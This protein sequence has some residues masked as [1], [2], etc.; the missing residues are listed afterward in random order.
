[1]N[2]LVIGYGSIGERHARI[3]KQMGYHVS[4]VSQRLDIDKYTVFHSI[5]TAMSCK[6]FNYVIIANNTCDHFSAMMELGRLTYK[7]LL[8]IEKPVFD[9][10]KVTPKF[11]SGSVFVAYN[12]RFHPV[13]L[14]IYRLLQ[15]KKIY[16]MHVYCGQYLPTWR[17]GNNYQKS[18]SAHKKS[19]GGVLRDLSHELDYINWMTGGWKSVSSIGG[20]FSDLEIDSDDVFCLLLETERCPAISLQVNYLDRQPRREMIINAEKLS[21]K[22]DLIAGTLELDGVLKKYDVS[23]DATYIDQHKALINENF[24]IPC[25]FEQ[26]CDVLALIE[27][28]ENAFEKRIWK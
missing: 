8:L 26:G 9:F 17:I 22:A 11:R 6:K 27:N 23:S 28:S 18:Y 3:L 25:D 4:I 13:I 19:G 14:E 7:N 5:E 10:L 21:L 24:D 15:S 12:L 1:M 20:K 2:C 16:S